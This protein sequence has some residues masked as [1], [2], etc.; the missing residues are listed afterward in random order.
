MLVFRR[1][2]DE[3]YF[4]LLHR[5]LDAVMLGVGVAGKLAAE[6]SLSLAIVTNRLC[7]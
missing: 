7:P 5:I 6:R 2:V 1:R 3:V 4:L